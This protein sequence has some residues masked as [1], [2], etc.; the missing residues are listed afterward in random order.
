MVSIDAKK[1]ELVGAFKNDGR[2]WG[3]EPRQVRDHDFPHLADHQATPFGVCGLAANRGFVRVG[4]SA[5]TSAFAVETVRTWWSRYGCRRY[6][7]SDRLLLLADG[8]GA[9]G[10]RLWQWKLLLQERLAD[11]YGLRVTVCHY[12]T[13]ASKWNPIEHRLFGPISQHWAGE[14][15]T[16][17]GRMLGLIAGTGLR[18]DGTLRVDAALDPAVYA[19][20]VKTPKHPATLLNLRRHAVCPNW[21][22]TL[23]P[24]PAGRPEQ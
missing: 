3:V 1:R 13:G 17:L 5:N 19:K 22:Y 14:P 7:R 10:H 8:G 18:G 6:R 11:R 12:P 16:S 4:V 20:G 15:L 24:R 21:N 23:S 9:N 2:V